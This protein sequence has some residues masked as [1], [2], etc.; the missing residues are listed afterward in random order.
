MT[1]KEK[2]VDLLLKYSILKEGHNE[3][4][5]KCAIMAVDE[6]IEVIDKSASSYLD[7]WERVKEEIILYK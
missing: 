7:F 2:A 3:L 1:P 6:I 4:V 5:K